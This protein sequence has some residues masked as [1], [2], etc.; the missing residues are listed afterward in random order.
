M[1]M[2]RRLKS[3]ASGRSSVSDPDGL[4]DI[5]IQPHLSDDKPM[6]LDQE[7]SSSSSSS[8]HRDAEAST[9]TSMNPAKAE[10]TG[11]DL[12]KGMNDMTIS[13]DKEAE[14]VTVDGSGTEAG[15]IIV[16][17]IGGQNGKPKQ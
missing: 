10:E 11:A 12:P 7:S 5:V 15:Q 9:S 17:T 14:G 3:I 4:G 1:H 16:T 8:S 13:D 6:H 2:M